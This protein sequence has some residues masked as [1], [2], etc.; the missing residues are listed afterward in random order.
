MNSFPE[1]TYVAARS[2]LRIRA[3]LFT[4]VSLLGEASMPLSSDPLFTLAETDLI[5]TS[6][7]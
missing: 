6:N 5:I 7:H 2:G 4:H 1:T 3:S